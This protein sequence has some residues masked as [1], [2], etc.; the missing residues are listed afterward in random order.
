[1]FNLTPQPLVFDVP[2][3][4]AGIAS[5]QVGDRTIFLIA[6]ETNPEAPPASKRKKIERHAI[7][8]EYL[9]DGIK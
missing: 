6:I 7:D 2:D 5:L 1:V 4:R 9:L 3:T 8:A